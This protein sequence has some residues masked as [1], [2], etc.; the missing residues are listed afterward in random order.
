MAISQSKR[1]AAATLGDIAIGVRGYRIR[2]LEKAEQRRGEI[3]RGA[4]RA[5]AHGGYDATNMDQIARECGLAKGHIYHYFRSKEEIFIEIKVDALTREIARL[6]PIARDSDNDPELALREAISGLITRFLRKEERYEP[7][8]PGPPSLGPENRKRLRSLSRRIEQIFASILASGM[9]RKVFVSGD[10]KLMTYVILR[11]ANSVVDWYRE[12][13]NWKLE[14][15][16]ERVTDQLLRGVL[17]KGRR[18]H[19]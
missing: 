6:T 14:W 19:A 18:D 3:L 16:A 13:G 9:S 12:S 10:P 1:A 8:M 7:L 4:A 5:F 11:A 15:I 17:R 2:D